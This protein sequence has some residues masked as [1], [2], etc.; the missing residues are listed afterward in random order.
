MAP[1]QLAH[2]DPLV[3]GNSHGCFKNLDGVLLIKEFFF[4]IQVFHGYL[5]F[6]HTQT[7]LQLG[8]IEHIMHIRQLRRHLQ[9]VC[10]FTSLLQNL[11]LAS[12]LLAKPQDQ[13]YFILQSHSKTTEFGTYDHIEYQ[14]VLS[15]SS[16]DSYCC[17]RTQ[18]MADSYPNFFHIVEHK[19]SACL[20]ES[21]LLF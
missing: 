11:E 18:H 3:L 1:L 20:P 5:L 21:D 19:L 12:R 14:T 6:R 7:F 8:D 13:K 2:L 16:L 4:S 10:Y 9:L 17:R 15:S